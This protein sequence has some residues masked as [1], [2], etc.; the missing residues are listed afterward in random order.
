M[1][2]ICRTG[3]APIRGLVALRLI[4]A[5]NKRTLRTSKIPEAKFAVF[6][7][8]SI[9]PREERVD[10]FPSESAM[11]DLFM[12]VCPPNSAPAT[13][14]RTSG[15][16]GSGVSLRGVSAPTKSG[17]RPDASL[18]LPSCRALTSAA[19][20]AAGLASASPAS[21]SLGPQLNLMS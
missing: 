7:A 8:C 6:R 10:V 13:M 2:F 4:P 11:C 14:A 18:E 21:I 17:R 20:A 5:Q 3:N 15:K 1:N 12:T 9:K 19:M 16:G